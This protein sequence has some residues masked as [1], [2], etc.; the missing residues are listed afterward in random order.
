MKIGSEGLIQLD[1]IIPQGTS[2]D[3]VVKHKDE[4]GEV[5]DH[6]ASTVAM[7]FQTCDG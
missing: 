3:F 2:F 5:I 1:L 4:T 7:A 6:S